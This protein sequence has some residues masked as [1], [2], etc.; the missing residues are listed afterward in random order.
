MIS[1]IQ[2]VRGVAGVACTGYTLKARSAIG[3]ATGSGPVGWRF[4]PSRACSG[5]IVQQ[6]RTSGF[7]PDNLGSTPNGSIGEAVMGSA[8]SEWEGLTA[9]FGTAPSQPEKSLTCVGM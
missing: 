9:C 5:P 1:T 4:D 3:S 6:A 7:D 2:I 8:N